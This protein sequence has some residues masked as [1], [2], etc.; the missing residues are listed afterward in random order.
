MIEFMER[1]TKKGA[2]I[3]PEGSQEGESAVSNE[4]NSESDD[5][6]EDDEDEDED[7]DLSDEDEDEDEEEDEEGGGDDENAKKKKAEKIKKRQEEKEKRRKEKELKQKEKEKRRKERELRQKEK[8]K[9]KSRTDVTIKVSV[10]N[11][12]VED[13]E[14]G[15]T[16]K[17]DRPLSP[18]QKHDRPSSANAQLNK[19]ETSK[20]QRPKS[21]SKQGDIN[22]DI[23][24]N[25]ND[26]EEKKEATEGLQEGEEEEKVPE[27]PEDYMDW[28]CMVCQTPNHGLKHNPNPQVDIYFGEKGALYRRMYAN[29]VFHSPKPACKKCFTLCDYKPPPGSAHIF[30]HNPEP[31]V[32]F[33]GYP[34]KHI[35]I[36]GLETEDNPIDDGQRRIIPPRYTNMVRSF[37][38]GKKND[39]T[40]V[41][42]ENDWR[43]KKYILHHFPKIPKYE[44]KPEERY[45]V[46][47]I[48]E[49]RQQKS[50]FC[51]ARVLAVHG[52]DTYD[53]KY[54]G[55]DECRFVLRKE[56]RLG[57]EK[58]SFAYRVEM[59]A[60][61]LTA[62]FPLC[63]MIVLSSSDFGL[64]FLTMFVLSLGLL[65]IRLK[66]FC[67]YAYNYIDAGICVIFR[68][69][70]FFTLPLF[71]FFLTSVIGVTSGKDPANWVTITAL[72]IMTKLFSLPVLYTIRPVYAVL[73]LFLFLQTSIGMLLLTIYC[74][75][76][77]SNR[78]SILIP[79]IPFM[80]TILTLKY[81]RMELH[82]V[83]DTC[84]VIRPRIEDKKS[85]PSIFLSLY[86][87]LDETWSNIKANYF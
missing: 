5:S 35:L 12:S 14:T 28:I 86:K 49:C 3:Q 67:Q 17:K 25:I 46:G 20:E 78:G 76:S 51:R 84:F 69:T 27:N 19:A 36:H 54:D 82:N 8:E 31:H 62:S 16:G 6:D 66:A 61:I 4:S 39:P 59:M 30:P 80:T 87:R 52:N 53:I 70:L 71:F 22:N 47:E 7:S 44:L 26:T 2:R 73:G 79:I 50:E 65:V 72:A 41:P 68:F 75:T 55:G 45:E 74:N 24:A 48:I 85:N 38:F 58:R 10:A 83:W 60:V 9:E 40:S 37:F 34:K 63:L 11:Q 33:R 64:V 1:F 15:D 57:T 32:A 13:V 81:L 42:M 77:P 43:L 29:L 21:A 23:E 18:A 56:I